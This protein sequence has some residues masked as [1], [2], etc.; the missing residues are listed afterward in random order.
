MPVFFQSNYEKHY[1]APCCSCVTLFTAIIYLLAVV[2]PFWFVYETNGL[3]TKHQVYWEQPNVRFKNELVLEVLMADGLA[4]SFSTIKALNDQ[5]MRP[6]SM[7]LVKVQA[8][9]YDSDQKMDFYKL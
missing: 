5:S 8:E 4:Y 3:W 2:L 6:L 7:P 9:D 1:R